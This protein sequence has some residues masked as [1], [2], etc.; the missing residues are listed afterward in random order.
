MF[1]S[2]EINTLSGLGGLGVDGETLPGIGSK[3]EASD[4]TSHAAKRSPV[5]LHAG[6][7]M[8]RFLGPTRHPLGSGET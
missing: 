3:A 4:C 7:P 6:E 8:P 1:K 5:I 2:N